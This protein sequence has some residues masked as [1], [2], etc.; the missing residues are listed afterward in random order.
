MTLTFFIHTGKQFK[1][2]YLDCLLESNHWVFVPKTYKLTYF[3]DKRVKHLKKGDPPRC[4]S[5][6]LFFIN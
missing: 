2:N 3:L 6:N 1:F 4:E 5:P